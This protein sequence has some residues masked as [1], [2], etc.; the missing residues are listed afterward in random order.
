MQELIYEVITN[1]VGLI[2][3]DYMILN[4]G[5]IRECV[6]FKS[7]SYDLLEHKFGANNYSNSSCSDLLL[8]FIVGSRVLPYAIGGLSRFKSTGDWWYFK[9]NFGVVKKKWEGFSRNFLI[10]CA[11]VLFNLIFNKFKS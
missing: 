5:P 6:H 1:D 10:W 4:Q 7:F 11:G 9:A 8:Q 3:T 2:W